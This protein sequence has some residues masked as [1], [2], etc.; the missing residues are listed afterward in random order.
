[1]RSLVSKENP[2]CEKKPPEP[3]AASSHPRGQLPVWVFVLA[4]SMVGGCALASPDAETGAAPRPSAATSS[5]SA[6]VAE[7][8]AAAGG[9]PVIVTD[10]A[11]RE[12]S[13]RKA[14]FAPSDPGMDRAPVPSTPQPSEDSL[15]DEELAD[16]MRAVRLVGDYE[17]TEVH[18][19][20]ERVRAAR[21]KNA[22]GARLRVDP[23][24]PRRWTDPDTGVVSYSID[25]TA[26]DAVPVADRSVLLPS[27]RT[28]NR[29]DPLRPAAW[30]ST[31]IESPYRESPFHALETGG[32]PEPRDPASVF[33]SDD[34]SWV[35]TVWGWPHG[36]AIKHM[37]KSA[38]AFAPEF[39][40]GGSATLIGRRTAIGAAHSFHNT[41]KFMDPR[42]WA[43]DVIKYTNLFTNVTTTELVYGTVYDCYTVTIPLGYITSAGQSVPEDFAVLEFTCGHNPG[44]Y[45]GWIPGGVGSA[46]DIQVSGTY[47][48]GYD[49]DGPMPST[50]AGG[51]SYSVGS[52]L[53]RYAGGYNAMVDPVEVNLV[54]HWL[55]TTG[56]ASGSGMLKDLFWQLGDATYYWS[57]VHTRSSPDVN[58]VEPNSGRRN[59][60]AL[61]WFITD[62]TTEW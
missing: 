8:V 58:A 42:F 60:W 47:I 4:T 1:M 10:A 56:G 46:S 40:L 53:T 32:R 21:A 22:A 44:D 31:S 59:D 54:K 20:V 13:V 35:N 57:A 7:L 5:R 38:S 3:S 30:R 62:Y 25:P 43:A 17:F 50:I 26:N 6:T 14:T 36:A 34:R 28:P 52:M 16:R 51:R 18:G 23:R 19:N 24:D 61:W 15:T 39:G 9:Q 55:D 48:E 2:S 49:H 41:Q 29:H 27:L 12:W 45:T 11:G 33:G 37:P